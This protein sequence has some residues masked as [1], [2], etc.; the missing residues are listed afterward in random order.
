[1]TSAKK[2]AVGVVLLGVLG[3]FA[4]S[5]LGWFDQRTEYQAKIERGRT[6][7]GTQCALCHLEPSPEILPK[8]SWE[9]VLG[10]MGFKLGMSN[11]D[12]LSGHPAFGQA[13][14]R[15]RRAILARDDALPEVPVLTTDNWDALRHYFTESA[16]DS[17]LEQ[18]GK[19]ELTWALPQFR[20]TQ[21]NY[22]VPQAVTT[23]V[24]IREDT[25]QVYIGDSA[26]RT[27]TTLGHN[28]QIVAAP[29]PLGEVLPVDIVF[30]DDRAYVGSIGDLT[31]ARPVEDKLG[32]IWSLELTGQRIADAE[33]EALIE[34]IYRMAD[35][36]I[37][38]LNSDGQL[39]FIACGFGTVVGR[40]SWFESQP[41]GSYEERLLLDLPGS[42]KVDTHDLNGDGLEDIVVLLSDAKEGLHVL[43]NKGD[44]EFE[45]R[46]IFQTH[47]GYGHTYFEL[48]D[49]DGDERMDLLVVN[50]DNVDSDP[51]NTRKNF[52]G[53]RIYL[54]QGD[55]RF[56]E[57]FFYP[58]YGAFIAKAADFD[59]DGD[60]DIAAI[61]FYPDYSSDRRESFTYLE[62]QGGFRFRPYTDPELMRGRWM[63][64][65]IGDLDGDQDVD[66][67]L[68]GG[69]HP[70]GMLG[71]R[72]LYREL[73]ETGPAVLVLKN[74]RY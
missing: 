18:V 45:D 27:L 37:V 19:P 43:V 44:N 52:H 25:Q 32:S 29:K 50:G 8:R 72:E 39:D 73:A 69:Y 24:H 63:T 38:D 66:V 13:N 64:M 28:G 34:N 11:I 12:H 31:A 26:R 4:Y 21:T 67:V 22:R 57:A 48:V 61:A 74:T 46:L 1:M 55:L 53:V 40:V 41:D 59:G 47:P 54:N 51:Y 30:S 35:M 36:A 60:M 58:M 70:V 33:P 9:S 5:L 16:P 56:E 10:Y 49:F 2:L 20:I 65:D 3:M 7:A 68:G 15:S 71:Y 23:L 17:P 14:V 42:V 6:L 62:N